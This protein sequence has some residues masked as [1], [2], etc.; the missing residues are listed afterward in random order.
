M[1]SEDLEELLMVADKIAVL[2]EGK[3]IGVLPSAEA[4]TER[5]GM[6]MAGVQADQ[7]TAG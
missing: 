7:T 6:M 5:L 4:D 2:F 3:I 1:V